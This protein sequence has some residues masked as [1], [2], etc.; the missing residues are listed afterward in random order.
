MELQQICREYL[1]S[2]G[3]KNGVAFV[4]M[5]NDEKELIKEIAAMLR[6]T[7]DLL[8]QVGVCSTEHKLKEFVEKRI[9]YYTEELD[10]LGYFDDNRDFPLTF[11]SG[12][13]L[14]CYE[15]YTLIR[16]MIDET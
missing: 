7:A 9:E 14:G 4:L 12:K 2:Q 1:D 16:K 11:E 8:E 6:E 3:V 15:A 10:K 5:W 13:L